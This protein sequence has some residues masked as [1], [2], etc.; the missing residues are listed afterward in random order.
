MHSA[1]SIACASIACKINVGILMRAVNSCIHLHCFIFEAIE[2]Q[3]IDVATV[4]V[5]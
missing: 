2:A 3:A 5:A 4:H 1:Q